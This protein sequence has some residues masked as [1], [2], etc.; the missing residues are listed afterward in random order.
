MKYKKCVIS[1]IIFLIIIALNTTYSNAK[2]L[3]LNSLDTDVSLS[4]SRDMEEILYN[5]G[6]IEEENN[7]NQKI[8]IMQLKL[9]KAIFSFGVGLLGGLAYFIGVFK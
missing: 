1:I 3:Q 4:D 7:S 6:Q 8:E 9:I 5:S 2:S